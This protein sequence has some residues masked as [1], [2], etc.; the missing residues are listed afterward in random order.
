MIWVLNLRLKEGGVTYKAVALMLKTAIMERPPDAQLPARFEIG[1]MAMFIAD[2][3]ADALDDEFVNNTRP[4]NRVLKVAQASI[5]TAHNKQVYNRDP[6]HIGIPPAI[7]HSTQ[8]DTM[9]KAS[10][11]TL[12]SDLNRYMQGYTPHRHRINQTS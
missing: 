11:S 10:L 1:N 9:K 7:E 8:T 4:Q 12:T 5:P 2:S 6:L 3:N